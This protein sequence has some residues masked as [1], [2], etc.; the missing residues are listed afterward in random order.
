VPAY[1]SDRP[2]SISSSFHANL[3]TSVP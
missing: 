2:C 3:A 1:R